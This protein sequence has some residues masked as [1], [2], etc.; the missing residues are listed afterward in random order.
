MAAKAH[1]LLV[2]DDEL[3]T[4]AMGDYFAYEGYRVT[5]ANS[6]AQA[7]AVLRGPVKV[8]LVVLDYRMPGGNATVLL[9]SMA[10]EES[11]QK[12]S[13]ILCSGMINESHAGETALQEQLPD[14]ALNLIRAYVGK[15]YELHKMAEIIQTLLGLAPDKSSGTEIH[16]GDFI[17][18]AS[19]L[20][21]KIKDAA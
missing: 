10:A 5:T 17:H 2:D 3:I 15:P 12:P 19:N 13:I 18:P 6:C 8:D 4:C 1:I 14:F 20:P 9:K 16:S 11:M 21:K 7:S